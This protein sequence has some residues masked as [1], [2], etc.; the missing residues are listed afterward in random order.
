MSLKSRPGIVDLSA[1]RILIGVS[2][3]WTVFRIDN[4]ELI[5]LGIAPES[6]RILIF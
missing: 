3:D 5:K 1:R 6:M 4:L 2:D